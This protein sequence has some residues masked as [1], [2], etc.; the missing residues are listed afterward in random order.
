M[1]SALRMV[2]TSSRRVLSSESRARAT[3]R[4]PASRG[5]LAGSVPSRQRGV[6][7]VERAVLREVPIRQHLEQTLRAARVDRGQPA[8][9]ADGLPSLPMMRM[10][11]GRSLTMIRPSGR[12]WNEKAP[13][14]PVATV[15]TVKLSLRAGCGA[16]VCP[17]HCGIGA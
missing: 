8:S 5:A 17:A 7:E 13:V 3:C 15:S 14:S 9:G 1:P 11:P 16:R 2:L 4:M 10:R 6:V 12:K